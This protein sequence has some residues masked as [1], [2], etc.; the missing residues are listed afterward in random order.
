MIAQGRNFG[1]FGKGGRT[2]VGLTFVIFTIFE[3]ILRKLFSRELM[4]I[5][6]L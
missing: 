5:Q 1:R 4:K 6:G 3:K 2:F